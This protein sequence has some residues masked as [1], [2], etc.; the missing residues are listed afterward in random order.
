MLKL[1]IKLYKLTGWIPG[2]IPSRVYNYAMWRADKK[3]LR[4]VKMSNNKVKRITINNVSDY[5]FNYETRIGLFR[6]GK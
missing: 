5:I 3:K 4:K 1:Y 2:E 6:K